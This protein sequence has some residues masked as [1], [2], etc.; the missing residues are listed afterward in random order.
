MC[1]Y[2]SIVESTAVCRIVVGVLIERSQ[3]FAVEPRP[4]DQYAF[5]VRGENS[6][7]FNRTVGQ[8]QR[9]LAL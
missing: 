4:D 6:G 9:M 8:A 2:Q 1:I 7:M 3:W 5:S